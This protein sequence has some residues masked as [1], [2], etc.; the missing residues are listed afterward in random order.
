MLADPLYHDPLD[1]F[2]DRE[3]LIQLVEHCLRA[4]QPGRLCILAV[5]GNSGTG[6]TFLI[7]Y[8]TTHVCPALSWPSGQLSF[9]QSRLDFRAIV[10]GLEA[11]LKG[12]VPR[13]S[14][15]QYRAKRD[16]YHLRFDD[17][18]SAITVTQRVEASTQSSVSNVTQTTQINIQL[19][20]RELQLRS[21]LT[22]ALLEL[23]EESTQPLCLFIDSYERLAETAP[24]LD[25]WLWEEVVV[26][27]AQAAP[28]PLV[29][30]TCGWE[31]PGNAAITPFIQ[32][33]ALT[34]FNEVQVRSYLE[35][36]TI[37]PPAEQPLTT[38]Q[39]EL[40][41]SFHELTKGH[42]LVLGL[43]VAYFNQ[44][45][46]QERTAEFLRAKRPL[47]DEQARVA[48]L[49]ERL[50]SQL[51][52]PHRT[53]LERGPILRAF[54]R[55]MLQV[56]LALDSEG[57]TGGSSVLDERTYARF[58]R[59]PFLNQEHQGSGN[60]SQVAST[61]HSL[62]RR[63]RLEALRHLY[64]D[65]K[66]Q[67]HRAMVE[68]YR[69]RVEEERE[70][71]AVHREQGEEHGASREEQSEWLVEMSEPAFRAHVEY[72]Y[73]ALQLP[74]QQ[75][76]A[77]ATWQASMGQAIDGWRR[78]QAETL[79]EVIEQLVEEGE[80][81]LSA[82]R[83][84]YGRYLL[85]LASS[86]EQNVRWQE[87]QAALEKAAQV[88]EQGGNQADY[89]AALNNLAELYRVQ[90]NYAQAE[91]L[92]K[93]SLAIWE[94]VLGPLHPHTASSLNNLA[95]LYYARGNY[96]QAEPLY[97]RALA[98]YEQVLGPRHPETATTRANYAFLLEE[99]TERKTEGAGSQ[100][101]GS[102]PE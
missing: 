83:E 55:Q 50:L 77:F 20:E 40:V 63:V 73:H 84:P 13:A 32:A 27:L 86:L 78:Q 60:A 3:Q 62:V 47:L 74:A 82:G 18:R 91:P 4:A 35:K 95:A 98:I 34:D 14:L 6:K 28:Q 7:S 76:E 41:A 81:F 90:G 46:S 26:A 68:Y 5:T 66:A 16:D 87:A 1:S 85:W 101:E 42:P 51:P 89:S 2:T 49:D 15:N 12:C 37:I 17:Y 36:H 99:M 29:V 48:F 52:E 54:D 53:L 69:Q 71:E 59:Y 57:A 75:A 92:M 58:L 22:R 96:E 33:E 8:L 93:R 100:D 11:A 94:Q 31:R 45:S 56:L 72:L 64:P 24:E 70:Q 97:Q 39:Q 9:A 43:A 102:Q 30:V 88:F 79:L 23:A 44:L 61:F 19:H 80:P 38:E 25:A 67:L 10:A 21:E 65:T